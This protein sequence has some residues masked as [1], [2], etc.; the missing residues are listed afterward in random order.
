MV[1]V[2]VVFVQQLCMVSLCGVNVSVPYLCEMFYVVPI[3][4]LQM[5]SVY[6]VCLCM[7]SKCSK[8]NPTWYV[9]TRYRVFGFRISYQ[10]PEMVTNVT[11]L[12]IF[13]TDVLTKELMVDVCL[14]IQELYF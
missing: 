11:I 2:R 8:F 9:I 7:K 13:S 6:C 10:S 1:I 12:A 3:G 4:R 5:A 14:I